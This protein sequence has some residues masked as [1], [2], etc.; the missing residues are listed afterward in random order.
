MSDILERLRL[1]EKRVK[2]GRHYGFE[3]SI[4][5]D[6]AD[7]IKRLQ[8][9]RDALARRVAEWE[10]KAAAWM[11][12]PEAIKKLDG[13]R[14]MGAKCAA[15]EA[16]LE[17]ERQS[18]TINHAAANL[19]LDQRDA[20]IAE[21]RE[22]RKSRQSEHDLR[23]RLAGE[24]ESLREAMRLAAAEA[25]RDSYHTEA[26]NQLALIHS[27][28]QQIELLVAERD[29]L[30]K[31]AARYQWLRTRITHH[32]VDHDYDTEGH[33]VPVLAGISNR[34]WYHATDDIHSTTLDE[35]ID[36]SIDAA[37]EEKP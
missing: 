24:V 21:L 6:A 10:E 35:L 20:A 7:E 16:E 25:E 30:A 34:L 31:D 12:S 36:A 17:E 14:E 19:A 28:N 37:R 2:S 26:A 23:V 27:K 15:L 9:E 22:A 1:L 8:V 11:A 13:Y 4:F 3:Q 29:A 32:D 33:N 5:A 18:R